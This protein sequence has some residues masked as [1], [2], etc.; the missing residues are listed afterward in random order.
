MTAIS[1]LV[2]THNQYL[3]FWI[4]GGLLALFA[5]LYILFLM[6]KS[7]NAVVSSIAFVIIF[8]CV[9]DVFFYRYQIGMI[10]I[11]LILSLLKINKVNK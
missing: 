3:Q 9:S 2:H 5:F 6:F 10:M 4:D 8:A 1:D 7:N 11:L